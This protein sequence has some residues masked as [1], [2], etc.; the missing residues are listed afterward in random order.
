MAGA[1]PHVERDLDNPIASVQPYNGEQL[2]QTPQ[3]LV[4][5]FNGLNVPALMGTSTFRSRS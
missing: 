1:P 3:K 4:V 5:T 2:S